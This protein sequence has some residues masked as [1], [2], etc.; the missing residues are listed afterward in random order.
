MTPKKITVVTASRGTLLDDVL[1][2]PSVRPH[3]HSLIC[4]RPCGAEAVAQRHGVPVWRFP[5]RDNTAFSDALLAHL[6]EHAIDYTL[7][8]FP[9]LLTGELLQRQAG[10][11]LNLHPS[12]LP[13]FPGLRSVDKALASSARYLGNTIH[14]IDESVDGGPI[15]LQSALPRGDGP[16]VEL[17]HRHFVQQCRMVIQL[18]HWLAADRIVMAG[19]TARVAD[20]RFAD[21]EFSPNLDHPDARQFAKAI[22]AHLLATA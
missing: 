15:V 20:A 14:F 22:P 5:L 7:V 6:Q 12:L 21:A 16:E 8:L 13:A 9:R 4:D 1:R 10:R 2:L 17:R 19:R 3:F 18:V 11:I